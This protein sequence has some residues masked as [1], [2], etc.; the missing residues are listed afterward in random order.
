MGNIFD[1]HKLFACN[2]LTIMPVDYTKL[3]SCVFLQ[4][5]KLVG[6]RCLVKRLERIQ[7]SATRTILSELCY[8]DRLS[9]TLRF[10]FWT[11]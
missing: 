7:R 9:Y 6:V 5:I 11:Q 1:K 8:E 2:Y 3:D 4:E 10:Y